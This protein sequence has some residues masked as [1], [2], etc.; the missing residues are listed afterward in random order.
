M[1]T[2]GYPPA[3][4]PG[5]Y[6]P[7]APGYPPAGGAYPPPGGAYPQNGAYPPPQGGG[8]QMPPVSVNP[9]P[10]AAGYPAPQ[11]GGAYPP[12]QQPGGA[13]PPATQAGGYPGQAPPGVPMTPLGPTDQALSAWQPQAGMTY[14][15]SDIPTDMLSEDHEGEEPTAP[16]L[17][18]PPAFT[19]YEVQSLCK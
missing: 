10:Q 9:T 12:A 7:Q 17:G 1:A 6:P 3:G 8:Y 18:P 5:A 11:P 14:Q 2:P 13:Y 19:G 16:P 15:G 4:A